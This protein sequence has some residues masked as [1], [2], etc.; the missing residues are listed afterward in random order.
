M[1]SLV[2]KLAQQTAIYGVSSILARFLNYALVPIQT[3]VF[4]PEAFGVVTQF[5]AY[6]GFLNILFTY[7]METAFFRYAT[8]REDKKPV[9]DTGIASILFTSLLFSATLIVFRVPIASAMQFYGHTEYVTILALILGLDAIVTI[10]FA[11]LRQENRPI[12]FATF[13]VV[14]IS[15]NVFFNIL[16]LIVCPCILEY[17]SFSSICGFIHVIYNPALGVKYIFISSLIASIATIVAMS[18]YFFIRHWKISIG[19]WKEMLRYAW[20]LIIV[21]LAGMGNEL[22]SRI[23]L[24][25]RWNGTYDEALHA[26]GVFGACYKMS[27]LMTLFVQAYRMAAEPFFFGESKKQ[28]PQLTYARTMNFFVIFCCF[29]FLLVTL[30]MDFFKEI[31]MGK[32]YY[33]GVRV[34]PVLLMANFFLGVYYNL[35]IWYKLTNKNFAGSLIAFGGVIITFL[36]NWLWIPTYGYYGSSWVTF[37]CYGSMMIVSFLLGQRYYPVP[38]DVKRFFTYLIISVILFISG[39]QIISLSNASIHYLNYLVGTLFLAAFLF[40]VYI[41]E[42]GQIKIFKAIG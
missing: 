14:N 26:L 7:G 8:L 21:G 33:E 16:F 41:F 42:T 15:F 35:T 40:I 37:I 18:R 39:N 5:Y 19:L 10:P 38:Y 29:I 20:P 24:T 9:Y 4:H 36:L 17:P 12:R 3:R 1:N 25:R 30:F 28:N 22:L 11:H 23:L 27:L 32:E 13:K 31:F 34:V 6:A 2:K